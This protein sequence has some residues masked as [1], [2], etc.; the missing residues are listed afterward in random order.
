MPNNL[1]SNTSDIVLKGFLKGFMASSVL[2]NT[3]DTQLIEGEINPDTGTTVRLKRPHQYRSKRTPS[4]DISG[5]NRNDIVSG[6]A[7]AQARDYIT[8]DMEYSQLEQATQLNE[9]EDILMPAGAQMAADLEVELGQF[10][11]QNLALSLGTAGTQ[12]SKWGDVA[13]TGSYLKSI[14]CPEGEKYGVMNPFAAQELADTQSGL[15]SGDNRLVNTAW[16]DAQISRNLGGVRGLM[17]NALASHTN[18]D[19]GAGPFTISAPA[20]MTY[21]SVKDSYIRSV[22]IGGLTPTTGTV[23][24]GDVIQISGVNFVNLKTRQTFQ[25]S[26]GTTQVFQAVITEDAT[27]DGSGN[28]VVGITAPIFETEGQYNNIDVTI[29]GGETVTFVSGGTGA[30]VNPSLFYHKQ[31]CGVGYIELPKLAV[32]ES[33]IINEPKSGISIRMTRGSDILGNNNIV[34]FDMLPAFACFNPLFG[35]RFYGTP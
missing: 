15:A 4:G 22:T 32:Q 19:R 35:G 34:R 1:G 14:G 5:Q 13:S 12:I 21:V 7:L 2:T 10:M 30:T 29:A 20:S 18:G 26:G 8:V 3:V 25:G 24:A 28:V 31:A 9:L 16:E 27:A 33:K 6:T 23:S 17:S 11:N